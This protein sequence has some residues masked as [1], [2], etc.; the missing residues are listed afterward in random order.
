MAGLIK[1]LAV[2]SFLE[3]L[4]VV[5]LTV[6]YYATAFH[7][8]FRGALDFADQQQIAG[9]VMDRANPEMPVEVQLF[10]NGRF[11]ADSEASLSRPDIVA[12]GLAPDALHGFRFQVP[13][14]PDGHYEARVYAVYSSGKGSRKTLQLIG[15]P[16][17]FDLR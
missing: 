3:I 15:S 17:A 1:F 10:I 5:A 8:S 11:I 16:R 9:W 6:G 13:E 2:K 4:F 7:P 14:M 12:A